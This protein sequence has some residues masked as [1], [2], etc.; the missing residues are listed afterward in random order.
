MDEEDLDPEEVGA[1][2]DRVLPATSLAVD[3][4][5]QILTRMS[6]DT[7][8]NAAGA[9]PRSARSR[10]AEKPDRGRMGMQGDEA[11]VLTTPSIER[12]SLQIFATPDIY[13]APSYKRAPSG[14]AS[15]DFGGGECVCACVHAW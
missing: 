4:V 6:T 13:Q 5:R 2:Q 3:R 8:A 12:H 14:D 11:R 7:E 10:P 15:A 9:P 1:A